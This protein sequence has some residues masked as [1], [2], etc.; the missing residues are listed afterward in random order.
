MGFQRSTLALAGLARVAPSGALLFACLAL[1]WVERGSIEAADWLPY[2]LLAGLLLSAL[3]WSGGAS[4]PGRPALLGFVALLG[5]AAWAAVSLTWSPAPALARD[6]ALLTAFYAVVLAVPLFSLRSSTERL[7]ALGLLVAA[8]AALA[9]ATALTLRLS[10][11]GVDL[12]DSGRLYF[13]ISYYNGQAALFAIGFWPAIVLAAR[14]QAPLAVRSVALGAAAT[15]LAGSLLAQSKGSVAALAVSGAVLLACSRSR[16]RVLVPTL[17][18]TALPAAALEALTGPFRATGEVAL[19]QAIGRAGGAVLAVGLAA[20]LLGALYTLVDRRI[21]PSAATRRVAGA[22]VLAAV[23]GGMA[24]AT[25]V[26]VLRFGG[27]VGVVEDKW[28][29]FKQP[30]HDESTGSHLLSLGSSRYDFARVALA[31]FRERPLAGTGARGFAT[32]YLEKRRGWETP[33]RAH[34]LELDVLSEQGLVGFGLLVGALGVPLVALAR[35][36]RGEL[37]AAGSFAAVLYWL[38]HASVDWIWTLPAVAIPFFLVLGIGLAGEG[39]PVP[40]QRRPLSFAAA[41]AAL[42]LVAF[43]PPWLAA[44]FTERALAG[45]GAAAS[46]LR[47]ARRLDPLSVNPLVSESALASPGRGRIQPL[48]LAVAMEPRSAALRHA[49]GLAY[50]EAGRI[51]AARKTLLVAR[52]LDPGDELVVRALARTRRRP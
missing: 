52:R 19:E 12:Y 14:R 17:L 3:L 32:A 1:A 6:E 36:A 16:L 2:A 45:E 44:R 22:V 51:R 42:A 5:L 9:I 33:A 30:P 13:P 21:E 18:A 43:A 26:S 23:L 50:L 4:W 24:T 48:E 38:L 29:A 15:L 40:A 25:A 10:A 31:E 46:D 8:G 47:W 39:R 37:L 28:E 34:S 11:R 7:A 41:V 20:T 27:P 35:R 49:L